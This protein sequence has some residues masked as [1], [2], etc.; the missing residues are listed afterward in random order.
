MNQTDVL[1][2]GAGPVGLMLACDLRRRDID[3]RIIDKYTEV[4]AT[5]RANGLQPRAVQVLD[6]LAIADRVVA[7]SYRAKGFRIL[8]DGTEV[9]RVEPKF[10]T[11]SGRM[12]FAN[13]AVVEEALRNKLAELGG[14]V[15][16]RRELRGFE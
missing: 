6:S 10:D 11:G 9:G 16:R 2:V 15:E 13:Q 1:I 14:H 3:C 8:R 12:I 7:K 4:P 5:S